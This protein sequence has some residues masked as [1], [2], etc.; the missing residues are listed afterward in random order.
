M[1]PETHFFRATANGALGEF[2]TT[3]GRFS[4]AEDFLLASY[5]A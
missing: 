5:E 2:L 4:E 3:Q 1:Y